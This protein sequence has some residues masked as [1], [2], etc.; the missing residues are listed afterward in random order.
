MLLL[1]LL[2]VLFGLVLLLL[3]LLLLFLLLLILLL[4][5]LGLVLLLLILFLLI[6]FVLVLFILLVL[7]LLIVL[8]VFVLIV[9]GLLV[10]LLLFQLLQ[11]FIHQVVIEL[12]VGVVWIQLQGAFITADG[13]LPLLRFL[14]RVGRGFAEPVKGVAAVVI[15]VLLKIEVRRDES[16]VE[17]LDGLFVILRLIGGSA[18]VEMEARIVLLVAQCVA[19]F[20]Q[21]GLILPGLILLKAAG[22]RS[23][24]GE[25]HQ[26][27][28]QRG[29][30]ERSHRRGFVAAHA[31]A[32]RQKHFDQ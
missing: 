31:F 20:A 25:A 23:V 3:L 26:Q 16:G 22:G 9:F 21:S 18:G 17:I 24:C 27:Q 1:L 11:F 4:L 19:V 10:L 7:L 30:G 28:E 6:L 8:F 13:V 12:R 29:A 2:L 14:F 32:I 15:R 5:L